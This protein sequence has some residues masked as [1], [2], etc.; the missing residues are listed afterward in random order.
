MK[1]IEIGPMIKKIPQ[2]ILNKYD[3]SKKKDF[4]SNLQCI[5]F[6]DDTISRVIYKH[7]EESSFETCREKLSKKYILS[8][9]IE[10]GNHGIMLYYKNKLV[11]LAN[12][13][14]KKKTV[15]IETICSKKQPNSLKG[16]PL[17]K[18]LLDFIIHHADRLMKNQ[19]IEAIELLATK[20]AISFYENYGFQQ[21][22]KGFPSK[23]KNESIY[24]FQ[25]LT[26]MKKKI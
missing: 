25:R 14:F 1:Q 6:K 21:K 4:A 8:K 19:K 15:H 13:K 24:P 18:I 23:Q 3:I 16:V 22:K 17:G 5:V 2:T 9:F 12:F 26:S 11:G 20:N 7:L 10:D